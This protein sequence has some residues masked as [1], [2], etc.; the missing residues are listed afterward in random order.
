M[1]AKEEIVTSTPGSSKREG[2]MLGVELFAATGVGFFYLLRVGEISNLRM[3]DIRIERE[4]TSTYLNLHIRGSKTDQ[5]NLGGQKRVGEV[6]R[7]LCPLVAVAAYL[8]VIE[9][10]QNS[11]LPLFGPNIRGRI[12]NLM[13]LAA[14]SNHVDASRIGT[15]SLRSG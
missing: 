3:K 13:K 8:S 5:Y 10:G 6:G 2:D 9:W 15:H 11:S 14:T 4:G 1:W 7:P 12:T